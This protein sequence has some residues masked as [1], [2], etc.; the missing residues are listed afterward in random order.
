MPTARCLHAG[1]GR[2]NAITSIIAVLYATLVLALRKLVSSPLSDI[3]QR[4]EL[5]GV[6]RFMTTRRVALGVALLSEG[7]LMALG[8]AIAASDLLILIAALP[9]AAVLLATTW[10]AARVMLAVPARLSDLSPPKSSALWRIATHLR[11]PMDAIF[12]VLT[13]MHSA[14]LL[15]ATLAL[16]IPGLRSPLM[17]ALYVVVVFACAESFELV[18]HTNIHNQVFR[19]SRHARPI[20]KALLGVLTWW[21]E[22]IL[23]VIMTRTPGWYR[24]HHVFVHHAENNGPGDPQSTLPY[25]RTSYLDFC[26]YALRMAAS[27]VVPWDTALYLWRRRRTKA[28]W[29]LVLQGVCFAALMGALTFCYWPAA[30]IMLALRLAAG[31]DAALLNFHEHGLIDPDDPLDVYRNSSTVLSRD[32][33]DH[34]GLGGDFHIA[35]HLHPG[36]HWSR[37]V[38]DAR[39][40]A[41]TYRTRGVVVFSEPQSIVPRLWL[42]RFDVIAACSA[43][44]RWCERDGAAEIERRGRAGYASQRSP[45]AAS[46]DQFIGRLAARFLV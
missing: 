23:T 5:A 22:C 39:T 18:D 16:L 38:A 40:N 12:T 45:A 7:L 13:L 9:I 15:P 42:R 35:H 44:G 31:V 4:L 6:L 19:A 36:R 11:H 2:I 14:L 28:F 24:I 8:R 27:G 32:A 21:H 10:A 17:L 37:L 1:H 46:A 3:Q 30:A 41:D 20:T 34:G 43:R 29:L 26:R 33:E 25:D